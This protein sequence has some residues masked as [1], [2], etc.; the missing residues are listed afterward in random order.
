M[1]GTGL[2]WLVGRRR[3]G[4]DDGRQFHV[5]IVCT[6]VMRRGLLL[7]L[8][9]VRRILLHRLLLLVVVRVMLLLVHWR[10]HDSIRIIRDERFGV[11]SDRSRVRVRV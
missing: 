7:L 3:C 6:N 9:V 2:W 5:I 11:A 1:E 10:Q 4:R 8:V